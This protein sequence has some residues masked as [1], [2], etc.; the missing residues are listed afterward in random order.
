M[1]A[2]AIAGFGAYCAAAMYA[3]RRWVGR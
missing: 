3:L 2:A 1:I